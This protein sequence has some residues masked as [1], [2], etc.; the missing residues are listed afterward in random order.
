[1]LTEQEAEDLEK[2]L[3]GSNGHRLAPTSPQV[4][5]AP[6]PDSPRPETITRPRRRR[7]VTP[8]ADPVNSPA[9]VPELLPPKMASKLKKPLPAGAIENHSRIAGLSSIKPMFVIERLNDIFG[10]GQWKERYEEVKVVDTT[11]VARGVEYAAVMIVVKGYLTVPRY[12]IE[13]EQFGGND[14]DDLGD[15]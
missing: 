7:N 13:I 1:M 5:V 8:I 3:A 14:N 4:Q 2:V 11:K 9:L 6:A 15:A 10:I 12:G